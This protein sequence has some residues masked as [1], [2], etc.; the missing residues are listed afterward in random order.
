MRVILLIQP[1]A[2]EHSLKYPFVPNLFLS[3]SKKIIFFSDMRVVGP[4]V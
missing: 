2:S 1:L 3:V 4:F